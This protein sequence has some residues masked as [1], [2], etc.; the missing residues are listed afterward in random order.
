MF[1]PPNQHRSL[2]QIFPNPAR[3]PVDAN[4][5][6]PK[7]RKL[8]W[9][10][11]SGFACPHRGPGEEI[12]CPDF[13]DGTEITYREDWQLPCAHCGMCY[14]KAAV[15]LWLKISAMCMVIYVVWLLVILNQEG[16]SKL[17]P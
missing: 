2:Q 4:A 8:K 16:L 15:K 5:K 12:P 17:L 14:R 7:M 10:Y 1:P 11:H 6:T 13:D 9:R 3:S